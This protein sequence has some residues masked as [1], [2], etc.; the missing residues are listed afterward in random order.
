VLLLIALFISAAG[1][2]QRA[3]AAPSEATVY[4]VSYVE[5]A[6][7][8]ETP[9]I[10]ALKQYRDMS[11]SE[12]GCIRIDIFEQVGRTGHFAVVEAWTDQASFDAHVAAAQAVLLRS[13]QPLRVSAYDQRPYKALDLGMPHDAPARAVSVV[14]HVDTVQS[15]QAPQLLKELA[16]RSRREEGNVRFD[17]LQHAMRANHFT[18]VETWRDQ[19]ALDRHA[20]A[21]ATRQY[22]DALQPMTGSPLDERVYKAIE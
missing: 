11:R 19:E 6:A 16:E 2:T 5:V 22:R 8:S 14:T 12:K 9:G 21:P 13:L 10:A 7:T 15:P 1:D 20:A 18:I 4:A 3:A 17:L